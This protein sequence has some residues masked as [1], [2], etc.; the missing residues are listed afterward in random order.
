MS[1]DDGLSEGIK[2]KIKL[3]SKQANSLS[4]KFGFQSNISVVCKNNSQGNKKVQY[5]ELCIK[6]INNTPIPLLR[7]LWI[8]ELISKIQLL[9]DAM[10][11]Y[12]K[13][14]YTSL[15]SVLEHI[16][17]KVNTYPGLAIILIEIETA[18]STIEKAF[19]LEEMKAPE[20]HNQTVH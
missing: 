7:A 1:L 11:D 4:Q 18:I 20:Y 5:T 17:N 10:S 9:I 14:S 12:E 6:S 16:Q 8:D 13:D 15:Q 19:E 3:A 2:S